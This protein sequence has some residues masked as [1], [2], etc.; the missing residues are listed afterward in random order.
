MRIAVVSEI[1]TADRNKDILK[2]LEGRGDHE[3]VNAGMKSKDE[4]PELNYNE[5]AFL[6]ALLLH[7]KRADFIV[8]GCSTGQGFMNSIL[9]YP[10]T[11]CGHI[12]TPLDAWLFTQINGGNAISL[13]LNQ[14][15][16]F[17][18]DEN[19]YFIFDRLLG[20]ESGSGYPAHRK[21]A[22][23][24][25]REQFENISKATHA[26]FGEILD[27]LPGEFVGRVL[28]FPGVHEIL[29]PETVEDSGIA[30]SLLQ[31]RKAYG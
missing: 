12:L 1:S 25:G 28:A 19:L 22:Q 13:T 31:H 7:T 29:E 14:S 2:A 9:Q 24:I 4:G 5:T 26:S 18:S 16:G 20:V 3:V 30:D 8:G 23:R 21:E 10:G 6:G 17:A 15:Y 27:R 11:S